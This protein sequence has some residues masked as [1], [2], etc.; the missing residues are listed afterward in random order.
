[1]RASVI[2]S[3]GLGWLLGAV[4]AQQVSALWTWPCLLG[5][6]AGCVLA[7]GLRGRF[8]GL[9]L[10]LVALVV[11]MLWAHAVAG[12]QLQKRLPASLEGLDLKLIGV[13]VRMPQQFAQGQGIVLRVEQC[14]PLGPEPVQAACPV[15]GL[16]RVNWSYGVFGFTESAIQEDARAERATTL[17]PRV[18][19]HAAERWEFVV[20]MKRPRASFNP[21]LYDQEQRWLED[22]IG[23]IASVRRSQAV[24]QEGWI[25]HPGAWVERLREWLCA[26]VREALVQ[27]GWG[28]RDAH[29][30][31]LALA[32][33]EQGALDSLWWERFNR[34][35]IAHLMSISGLHVTLLAGMV[36]ALVRWLWRH[37]MGPKW[38]GLGL[39]GWLPA[40]HAAW[41]VAMVVSFAY[42][43]LAG[44]GIPAQRTCWMILVVGLAS[45]TARRISMSQSLLLA[46]MVVLILD[47][48]ASLSPGFWLSFVGVA[49]LVWQGQTSQLEATANETAL[50]ARAVIALRQ[51]TLELLR[52]QWAATLGLLPLCA[53]FFASVSLVGPLLNLIAVP[54]ISALVTPLALMGTLLHSLGLPGQWLLGLAAALSDPLLQLTLWCDQVSWA[55][56]VTSRPHPLVIVL[57]LA[58]CSISLAPARWPGQRWSLLAL[59]P[60]LIAAKPWDDSVALKLTALDIGQGM[61]VVVETPAHALLYDTGPSIGGAADAGQKIVAPWL[62]AQ[63]LPH[64]GAMIVSHQDLDHSGGA[65]S[66]LRQI[67]VDWV[68][69]SLR[70]DHPIVAQSP[71]H[72]GCQRAEKWL[73]GDVGFEWLHPDL[74]EAPPRKSPSNGRSCVL[75]ITAGGRTVL[76]AGD[77]EAPQEAALVK[78]Y[79]EALQADILLAPHHGSNTSSTE[80]FLDA[81]APRMAIFQVGYRN[82][83]RHPSARVLAR[84]NARD[85]E[86]L[87]SDATGSLVIRITRAGELQV[88]KAREASRRYWHIDL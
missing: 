46:G 14:E 25:P 17:A 60:L 84:Y 59:L 45:M 72:F 36:A 54:W 23:A 74:N 34:T 19:V 38:Q 8:H 24:R 80:A 78:L 61:A 6:A 26:E 10:T 43:L 86:V 69:S 57:A 81:V 40:R 11:S 18:M 4:L 1:M 56:W 48:W 50:V 44:W 35:G 16:V 3:L 41:S 9:A 27:Q 73:W 2:T 22:G 62:R 67:K 39:A 33:G 42:S 65:L 55:S 66:I 83:Y 53:W 82:R 77:I 63:G 71:R 12:W 13:V 7:W 28:S 76:L 79:G 21:G 47:P 88:E 70:Q 29:N 58:G 52:T 5:W 85:I 37:R 51:H 32:M 20:R 75:K 15:G 64:L 87:R 68:A 30:L 49:V 31:V